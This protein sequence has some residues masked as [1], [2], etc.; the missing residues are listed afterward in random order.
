MSTFCTG[1]R[2]IFL[3]I[4]YL[5]SISVS[6]SCMYCHYLQLA[7]HSVRC[8]LSCWLSFTVVGLKHSVGNCTSVKRHKRIQIL[9]IL[10]NY[11]LSLQLPAFIIT[12]LI[13]VTI[14]I[15]DLLRLHHKFPFTMWISFASIVW[16]TLATMST[17][18]SNMGSIHVNSQGFLR[19]QTQRAKAARNQ[20]DLRRAL[21]CPT[22]QIRTGSF[23]YFDR[24]ISLTFLDVAMNNTVTV[25]LFTNDH[26]G[27]FVVP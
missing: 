19:R 9:I 3:E 24:S 21:A 10:T 15:V 16:L 8:R 27:A 17:I 11:F 20:I 14:P 1:L 5:N 6:R 23:G 7:W 26:T 4:G 22:V 13:S 2:N 12:S 18:C 25:L